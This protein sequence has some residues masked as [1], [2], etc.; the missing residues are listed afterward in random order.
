[1]SGPAGEPGNEPGKD[2]GWRIHP[3]LEGRP[4]LQP[5]RDSV[6]RGAL[7]VLAGH[8]V[9]ICVIGIVG[10]SDGGGFAT[11]AMLAAFFVGV[12]QWLYV[13]PLLVWAYVTRRRQT[14]KGVWIL[15]GAS[16]LPTAACFGMLTQLEF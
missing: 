2:E 6:G 15:A 8:A 9:A 1:M 13:V 4:D 16:L 5:Q 14:A 10:M 11:T 3:S 7:Y 12:Y